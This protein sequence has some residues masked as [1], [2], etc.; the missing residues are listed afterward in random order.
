MQAL[1][2]AAAVAYSDSSFVTP[3]G[4]SLFI[5]R[6]HPVDAAPRAHVL[7]LHG[8]F[9]HGG[10]YREIAH[11]LARQGIASIA[12]D[13]RGHGRSHGRRGFVAQFEH[14][15]DDLQALLAIINDT[16]LFILGH[17]HGGLVA[18]DYVIGRQ[19]K[20]AGLIVTNPFLAMSTPARGPKLWAGKFAGSY[21]PRLSLPSG[22][23]A[24][25]ISRDPRAVEMYK[26]DPMV[27]TMVNAAWFREVNKAQAR[28]RAYSSVHV[29]ILYVHSDCDP[30]A[31]PQANQDLAAQLQGADKTVDVQL[32]ALHEVL[33]ELDRAA[34]NALIGRWILAH[35]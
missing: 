6:W 35:C 15:L 20:V 26:R 16:P 3:D 9:E 34:L 28:V 19:A 33:N 31:S 11:A 30:I 5:R 22:L 17:S 18:L 32:G 25:G 14:Y 12:L 1:D 8:Y 21:L 27:F 29:P 2:D 4:V 10:R 23:D 7:I 24:R 13:M